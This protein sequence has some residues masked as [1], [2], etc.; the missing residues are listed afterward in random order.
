MPSLANRALRFSAQA[1]D[2]DDREDVQWNLA[3]AGGEGKRLDEYV[4]R[5]FGQSIPKQYCRL[6]GSRSMLEHTLG[7]LNQLTPPA[8]TLTV[9]GSEHGAHAMPQLARASDHVFCQPRARGTGVALYV[10]LAMIKRWNPN[11]VVTV[12]PTD[13]YVAPANCY[14]ERVRLAR[15]VSGRMRDV[16]AILGVAPSEPD[17]ELGYLRLGSALTEVPEAFRLN[18]FVE[19]PSVRDA[20]RLIAEGALWNTMV[21]CGTVAALWA[22]G[23]HTQPHLLDVLDGLVPLIG[24]S[25]EADAIEYIYQAYPA[26]DFSTD[27]LQRSTSP[28]VSIKLDDVEWSDWGRAERV[29]A[30]LASRALRS[31]T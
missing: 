1:P 10:A 26:I 25:D 13:H 8:R 16:I 23:R 21:F 3:L 28:L 12:T 30:V 22:M 6:L 2:E 15:H 14:L 24:T 27:V 17:P 9:I 18:G 20:S 4:Q 29:E 31:S 5:R 11:A 19:K 7:R